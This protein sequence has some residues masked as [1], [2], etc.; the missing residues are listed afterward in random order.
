M[1]ILR[2]IFKKPE[3]KE[4]NFE[5][6]MTLL[7]L[8]NPNSY[9]QVAIGDD[10]EFIE[11]VF[12]LY[13]IDK[14]EFSNLLSE[15]A[16]SEKH[17]HAINKKSRE[18][19]AKLLDQK[20]IELDV[21]LKEVINVEHQLSIAALCENVLL[22]DKILE[23]LTDQQI[24]VKLC[25]EARSATVRKKIAEKISD[26]DLLNTLLPTFKNKDKNTYKIIKSKIDVYKHDEQIKRDKQNKIDEVCIEIEQHQ[27]RVVDPYYK[28][29]LDRLKRLWEE[30]SK[31]A[32]TQALARFQKAESSCRENLS[33]Y[34]AKVARIN[35]EN[36]IQDHAGELQVELI[37]K[38]E[39]ILYDLSELKEFDS[40]VASQFLDQIAENQKLWAD[41]RKKNPASKY[42]E[43]H[44][45][46]LS[47]LSKHIID[48]YLTSGTL[49]KSLE[50]YECITNASQKP[51]S[52]EDNIYND[53]TE[54]TLNASL[55]SLSDLVSTFF[56]VSLDLY[57]SNEDSVLL[58][59][60]VL[61][62]SYKA[63][64]KSESE[65]KQKLIN[66]IQSLV[67]KSS[68][69]T[70]QG[71]LKQALGVRH[72]IDEK[73]SASGL[74]LSDYFHKKLEIL[75]EEIQKLIDWQ[76]YAVVPKKEKL[77]EDISK[78]INSDLPPE[79]LS[80]RIKNLQNQWRELKQSGGDRSDQ[81]WAIFK[82]K[83]DEAYEPCRKYFDDL[84]AQR[85][86]NLEKRKALVT[87]LQDFYKEYD[88][89]NADWKVVEQVIQTARKEL[90]KYVP[91][92]RSENKQVLLDFDQ[93]IEKI[94]L[95]LNVE[96]EKNKA[97]KE[98]LI[99][100]AKKLSEVN[101]LG[102]AISSAKRLQAQWKTIGLCYYRDNEALWKSFRAACDVVFNKKNEADSK[103][104]TETDKK[105][106][107]ANLQ[108]KKLKDLTEQLE[109][110]AKL[111]D[112][113]EFSESHYSESRQSIIDEY[114][115]IEDLPEKVAKAIKRDFNKTLSLLDEKYEDYKKAKMRKNWNSIFICLEEI[116]KKR[117]NLSLEK[118]GDTAF[119]EALSRVTYWPE[120]LLPIVRHSLEQSN[121]NEVDANERAKL[122]IKAEVAAGMSS[123]ESDKGLRMEYQVGMLQKGLGSASESNTR[124]SLIKEWIKADPVKPDVYKDYFS[125]FLIAL[126]KL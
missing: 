6:K 106:S 27:E 92:D 20:N 107:D 11:D 9:E 74:K 97:A 101:D 61:L 75:D 53:V 79:A 48:I 24:L 103:I 42:D 8:K 124:I 54:K 116:N 88:W 114:K 65:E 82:A 110:I 81:L 109:N 93:S 76:A 86:A 19:I 95:Y 120:G 121:S 12:R 96:R 17:S 59:A 45:L 4:L 32:S 46:Q 98:L 15:L 104:R 71:R 105:I 62:Q 117:D 3:P 26:Y 34:E 73:L 14:L 22:E 99:Q 21:F 51:T 10:P 108:I 113:S 125:R 91:V 57:L 115:S 72:S 43:K 94:Q 64:K 37:K 16:F 63:Q 80:V 33:V 60:Q 39:K 126:E 66:S 55:A 2:K 90:H 28:L 122:C 70:E 123:P 44:F 67:R 18:H 31:D 89:T 77:I 87:Q 83:S 30:F 25:R 118:E 112:E 50:D 47:D 36:Y 1:Q 56:S 41:L 29:E 102:Q 7:K 111:S 49:S 85:K 35:E 23:D 100:Q 40:N 78:L 52:E 5:E 119:E 38:Q 84:G 13:C 58:K 68:R 69:A